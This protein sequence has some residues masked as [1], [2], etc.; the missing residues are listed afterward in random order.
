[1]GSNVWTNENEWPIGRTRYAKFFLHSGGNANGLNGDGV[2]STKAPTKE[3]VDRYAYNPADPVPFITPL[4]W[5]QSGGPDDYRTVQV[6][7]DLLVYT[8]A[9]FQT[10][11]KMCGPLSVTLFAATSARDTD[12]TAMVLDVHPD[13]YAQRLNDG[14]V[15]ARFR[16]GDDAEVLVPPGKVEAYDIDAWSTCIELQPGHRVRLQIASSATGKF[17]PNLNT[18]G[19][20]G[21]ESQSVVAEQTVHHEPG[22][23]SYVLLPI[24]PP[25]Q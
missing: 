23:A 1:M 19:P 17:A 16:R 6:R 22:R 9:P 21:Q 2:L 24:V 12:W 5:H 18:G 25:R 15:R 13:G 20:L 4:S 8:S 3:P 7:K 10:A 14:I 11:I